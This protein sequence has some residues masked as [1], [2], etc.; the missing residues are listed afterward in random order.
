M[1]AITSKDDERLLLSRILDKAE[2][3]REKNYMTASKFLDERQRS[4][5]QQ[6]LTQSAYEEWFFYGGD[7]EAERCILIFLPEY[8][9]E[10][11]VWES[12]ENPL[13]VIR[14]V[15]NKEDELTHRDYL[16][17]LMG[18][19]LARECIGDIRVQQDGA[20]IVVLKEMADYILLNWQ[21][22]GRRR[23]SLSLAGPDCLRPPFEEF[24]EHTDT[25]ASLRLDSVLATI[26]RISRAQAAEDIRKGLATVSH[27]VCI[28]PDR[29]IKA[30]ERIAVR[31]RGKGEI[32]EIAGQS[33]K[34][35][36][37]IR[38]RRAK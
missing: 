32:L 38:I 3:C 11:T 34:G 28:K 30:M 2:A 36:V 4:L 10:E 29:E 16:G 21:R 8:L 9:T 15:K 12:E 25:V 35:R 33:R 17:S 18:L 31:G 26:F 23:L 13:A 7:S 27:T 14:A 24:E 22:A 6:L 37:I 19:G 20:D 5:A 1:T